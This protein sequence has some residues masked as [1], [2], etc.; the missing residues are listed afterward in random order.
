MHF[1]RG[2]LRNRYTTD[3]QMLSFHKTAIASCTNEHIKT[4][5]KKNLDHH[6]LALP[7]IAKEHQQP[8]QHNNPEVSNNQEKL[9][10]KQTHKKLIEK[11]SNLPGQPL[12]NEKQVKDLKREMNNKKASLKQET[13][14]D[15]KVKQ[16][17]KKSE[18]KNLVSKIAEK[19]NSAPINN[20]DNEND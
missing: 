5:R 1:I 17:I 15:I 9:E 18:K 13:K 12:P 3:E 8:E 6:T 20:D 14:K 16:E 11:K 19:D 7:D 4:V 10:E 2:M